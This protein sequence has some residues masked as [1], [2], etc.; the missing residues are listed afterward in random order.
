MLHALDGAGLKTD[1]FGGP[2]HVEALIAAMDAC[3]RARAESG[4][5]TDPVQGA[6]RLRAARGHPPAYRGTT[7]ISVADAD[8]NLAAL[9]V[10]NGEGCGHIVPATGIMLNNMLGEEDLNAA[11]FFNWP[12]GVRM[13]SM[14][15]PGVLTSRDGSWTA[16]GSGGSNRIRSALTQV[17]ANLC[18]FGQSVSDAVEHPR[19]HLEDNKL[20]LEPGVNIGAA[21]WPGEVHKWPDPNM[22]FGGAHVIRRTPEGTVTGAGDPR[23]DGVFLGV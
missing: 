6:V 14:M 11:G 4:I 2:R 13:S 22:F 12:E 17:I 7:H 10:S 16:F 23:R 8:G 5:D 20:S 1:N 18:V 3:N 19:L 9:T 21:R 15:T